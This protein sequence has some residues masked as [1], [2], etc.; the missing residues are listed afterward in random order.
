MP[1]RML[2][3]G[4]GN[5]GVSIGKVATE[6]GRGSVVGLF[7]PVDGQLARA[8]AQFPDA[9]AE[10]NDYERLLAETQPDAVAVAGPDHL[11]ADQAIAALECGCHVLVEKPLATTQRPDASAS[12]VRP[13]RGAGPRARHGIHP[14]SQARKTRTGST[15]SHPMARASPAAA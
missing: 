5:A 4:C 6:D 11:H 8:K 3:C 12:D 1:F 2:I 7:D 14:N 9:L 10:S 13:A 15:E